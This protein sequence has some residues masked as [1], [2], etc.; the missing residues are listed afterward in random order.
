MRKK[1][2]YKTY[3]FQCAGCENSGYIPMP[4]KPEPADRCGECVA[5]EGKS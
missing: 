4:R 1:V 3:F 5:W 2:R